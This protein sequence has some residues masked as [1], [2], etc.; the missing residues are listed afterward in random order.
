V[1]SLLEEIEGFDWDDGNA[2]KNWH[3]HR[4]TDAECEQ[5]F[6]NRPILIGEDAAHSRGEQRFAGYGITNSGRR[7]TVIFTIRE[8]M[9]RV[10]SARDMTKREEN[11]YEEKIKRDS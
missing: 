8:K 9:I 5:L 7:L 3:L 6:F 10:I 1:A 11:R 4:V 2:L